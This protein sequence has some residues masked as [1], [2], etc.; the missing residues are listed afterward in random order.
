M[1]IFKEKYTMLEELF[2]EIYQEAKLLEGKKRLHNFR[3]DKETLVSTG[4]NGEQAFLVIGSE[5]TCVWVI[6][7]GEKIR[8]V[9]NLVKNYKMPNGED[10]NKRDWKKVVGIGFL[11]L[12]KEMKVKQV[13]YYVK[14]LGTSDSSIQNGEVYEC[15]AEWYRDGKLLSLAVIDD[16]EEDYLYS[17]KAFEKVS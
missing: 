11:L 1:L 5:V 4:D 8:N 14:Y 16:T 13:N 3:I 2:E 6:A 9:G 7:E 15:I 17:P 12:G 10:T